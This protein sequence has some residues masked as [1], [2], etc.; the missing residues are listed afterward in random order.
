MSVVTASK[1]KARGRYSSGAGASRYFRP[2]GINAELPRGVSSAYDVFFDE[3]SQSLTTRDGS[4]S[5]LW[6]WKSQ[7][8]GGARH[9]AVS[10][11]RTVTGSGSAAWTNFLSHITDFTAGSGDWE[12][13]VPAAMT[14]TSAGGAHS[15]TW[16][17]PSGVGMSS[18]RL[19]ITYAGTLPTA[20]V[21]PSTATVGG[22]SVWTGPSAAAESLITVA[23]P[24]CPK[25]TLTGVVLRPI[26]G[27]DLAVI[28]IRNPNVPEA[29]VTALTDLPSQHIIDRCW[30]DGSGTGNAC[31]RGVRADALQIACLE[32]WIT[33]IRN[34]AVGLETSGWGGTS[35]GSY[36][37][38]R[39]V[40]LES[41]YISIL[42]GGGQPYN[43]PSN[44]F[45]PSD[46]LCINV[47]ANRKLSWMTEN[48]GGPIL[49]IKN[50]FE[51]KNCKRWMIWNCITHRHAN[52][53]QTHAMIFQNLIEGGDPNHPYN[54]TDDIVVHNHEFIDVQ[55]G[56]NLVG[57]ISYDG[58]LPPVNEASRL[59]FTNFRFRGLGTYIADG[60]AGNVM[61]VNGNLHDFEF[62]GWTVLKAAGVTDYLLRG[63]VQDASEQWS[64]MKF[65]NLV[66]PL[67]GGINMQT[68]S[69]FGRTGIAALSEASSDTPAW[70][71]HS[72]YGGTAVVA[73]H[74]PGLTW[75]ADA[76]AQG[77]NT[78]TGVLSSPG[79]DDGV[80]SITPG[81]N[82]TVLDAGI[83]SMTWATSR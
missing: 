9:A 14:M 31:R 48:A 75:Y 77:L 8:V 19:Y 24:D 2:T 41:Q 16:W 58:S 17:L 64:G 49:G 50:G 26:A 29:P 15:P 80:G 67:D 47:C 63:T 81:C 68:P 13:K 62:D 44:L 46:N 51:A 12:I 30:I 43:V 66:A 7:R 36:Q 28:D 21:M 76:A 57:T 38:L 32:T 71:G 53:G 60:Y 55:N 37:F 40:M 78:T 65:R 5:F 73:N 27:I 4:G 59:S 42:Y 52:T 23:S 18:R 11:T 56:L 61:Q 79:N 10:T 70:E 35:A 22:C 54:R 34:S 82:H 45:N 25:L 72:V 33:D 3:S 39:N 74:Q 69:G 6:D 20:D 1:R 83:S